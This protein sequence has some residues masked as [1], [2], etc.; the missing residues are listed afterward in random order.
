[1]NF[2]SSFGFIHPDDKDLKRPVAIIIC[3][4]NQPESPK[5]FN[6]EEALKLKN[7]ATV[8]FEKFQKNKNKKAKNGL[9]LINA[10]EKL[11]E[12]TKF[13][14]PEEKE[15]L[16]ILYCNLGIIFTKVD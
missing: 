8:L 14:P 4:P 2:Q 13:C 6:L 1:M 12:A 16:A 11:K 15:Q 3:D 7:Q 5:I 9:N 10:I